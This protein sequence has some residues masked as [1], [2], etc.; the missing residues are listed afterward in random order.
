MAPYTE[1]CRYNYSRVSTITHPPPVSDCRT[2]TRP[3]PRTR[4]VLYAAAVLVRALVRRVDE[5]L[6]RQVAKRAVQLD[7]VESCGVGDLR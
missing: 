3:S 5:E 1:C 7:A 6:M 2:P 4:A